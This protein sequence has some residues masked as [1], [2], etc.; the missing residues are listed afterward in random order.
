MINRININVPFSEKDEAKKRG[1][2][3]DA[4]N[5]T[6]YIIEGTN[7]N[8]FDRWIQHF[9]TIRAK[10]YSLAETEMSCWKCKK[11]TLVYAIF[12]EEYEYCSTEELWYWEKVDIPSFVS[13]VDHLDYM[14]AAHIKSISKNSYYL[15]YSKHMNT[16]YY[17]NHCS[18]C[19]M[20]QGDFSVH[21]DNPG[22]G[23][24]ISNIEQLKKIKFYK[25]YE[26]IE[27]IGETSINSVLIDFF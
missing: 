13:Y 16:K 2:K 11:Q 22:K 5:K 24:C 15:D 20:K 8:N 3:W 18:N 10:G 21:E 9:P 19:N 4:K 27:L 12:L 7:L 14:A 23:F 6:W 26:S 1:A 17:L 25:Y